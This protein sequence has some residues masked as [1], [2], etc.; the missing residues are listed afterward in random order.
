VWWGPRKNLDR[1]ADR[2]AERA[3][4]AP[5]IDRNLGQAVGVL[6]PKGVAGQQIA[7]G[8]GAFQHASRSGKPRAGRQLPARRPVMAL[9]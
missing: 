9:P 4:G 8:P 6:V 1:A 3:V 7:E 2:E 5:L